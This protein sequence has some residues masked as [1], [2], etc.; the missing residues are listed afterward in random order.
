MREPYNL[1]VTLNTA[2]QKLGAKQPASIAASTNSSWDPEN[3]KISIP[4]LA[5]TFI[6]DLNTWDVHDSSGNQVERITQ[7]LTLHYLNA[8]KKVELTGRMVT[9]KELPSAF[10]YQEPFYKRSIQPLIKH[11]GYSRGLLTTAGQKLFGNSASFKDESITV[12]PFPLTPLTLV[13]HWGDEEFA[14]NGNI[15]FDASIINY[16]S[17]ED[18]TI[19]ASWVV[20]ELSKAKC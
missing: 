18:C 12:Y 7:I 3:N 13:I 11:F 8:G 2:I 15:L 5:K 4:S 19:L 14:P 10:I 16:F 6:V 1:G 9:F 17:I 20:R